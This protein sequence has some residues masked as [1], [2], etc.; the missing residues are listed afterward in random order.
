MALSPLTLGEEPTKT[1]SC[2][3]NALGIAPMKGASAAPLPPTKEQHW[4][5]E[6]GS[7]PHFSNLPWEEVEEVQEVQAVGIQLPGL[8]HWE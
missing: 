4:A 1:Q 8:V 2:A 7:A 6:M 3:G 5:K